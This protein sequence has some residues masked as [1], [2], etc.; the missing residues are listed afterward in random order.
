MG[1]ASGIYGNISSF[2]GNLDDGELTPEDREAGQI[3][4]T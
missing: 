3:S 2:S 1:D 4:K